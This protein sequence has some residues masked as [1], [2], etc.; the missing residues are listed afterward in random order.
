M[1]GYYIGAELA[2]GGPVTDKPLP[3]SLFK[4]KA[5]EKIS[6]SDSK[7]PKNMQ[8][9][10]TIIDLCFSYSVMTIRHF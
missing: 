4:K 2:P 1:S 10:V 6:L 3:S 5:V 7:K 9:S 8:R